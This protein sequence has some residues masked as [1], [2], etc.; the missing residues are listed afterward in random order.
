MLASCSSQRQKDVSLAS[1]KENRARE[2]LALS[3]VQ[4]ITSLEEKFASVR[5]AEEKSALRSVMFVAITPQQAA[6]FTS[7]QLQV[8]APLQYD[9]LQRVNMPCVIM[10]L[11]RSALLKSASEKLH[12]VKLQF[13]NFAALKMLRSN[14]AP[15][16]NAP[17]KSASPN[18]TL[19]QFVNRISLLKKEISEICIVAPLKHAPPTNVPAILH[20][21]KSQFVKLALS[22]VQFAR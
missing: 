21:E 22:N 5:F 20:A 13:D 11:L 12:M 1:A 14:T 19:L 17:A 10:L 2:S 8:C 4:A 6:L 7:P 15:S 16:R 3:N 18:T 9:T